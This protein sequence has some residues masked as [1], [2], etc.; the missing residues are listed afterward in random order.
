MDD[1]KLSLPLY[2]YPIGVNKWYT[3]D[4]P[5]WQRIDYIGFKKLG[6]KFILCGQMVYAN[7]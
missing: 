6:R 1:I 5:K 7:P 3:P 4:W 2:W